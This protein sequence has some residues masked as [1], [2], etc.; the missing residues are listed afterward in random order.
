MTEGMTNVSCLELRDEPLIIVGGGRTDFSLPFFP[1]RQSACFF[2]VSAPLAF[3]LS[4]PHH[5]SPTNLPNP[6]VIINER[7][8]IVVF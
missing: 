6:Q 2:L 8:L 3:F 7:S 1:W 5:R 4:T